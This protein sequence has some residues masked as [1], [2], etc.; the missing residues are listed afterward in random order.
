MNDEEMRTEF[1]R[2]LEELSHEEYEKVLALARMLKAERDRKNQKN[3]K[4]S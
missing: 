2:L 3:H 4:D 1:K